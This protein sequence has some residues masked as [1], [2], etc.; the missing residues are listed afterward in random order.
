MFSFILLVLVSYS[1][2]V[3]VSGE[4]LKCSPI[5]IGSKIIKCS[6]DKYYKISNEISEIDQPNKVIS[7]TKRDSKIILRNN[8]VINIQSPQNS[9]SK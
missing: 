6:N 3:E 4:N 7:N 5:S 8:P 2:A 9:I 1:D